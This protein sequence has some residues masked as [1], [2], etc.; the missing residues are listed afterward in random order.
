MEEQWV[1]QMSTVELSHIQMFWEQM[2]P[3]M[4]VWQTGSQWGWDERNEKHSEKARVRVERGRTGLVGSGRN[5]LC[6]QNLFFPWILIKPVCFLH[7]TFLFYLSKFE[8]I[9]DP[10]NKINFYGIIFLLAFCSFYHAMIRTQSFMMSSCPWGMI[11]I[12]AFQFC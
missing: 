8:W 5:F 10:W 1:A 3:S 6:H 4:L 9:F 11:F 2:A 7:K 12:G